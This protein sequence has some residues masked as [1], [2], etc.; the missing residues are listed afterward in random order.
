MG[1]KERYSRISRYFTIVDQ[2]FIKTVADRHEH[3]VYHNKQ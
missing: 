2:Y 1:I 3:A